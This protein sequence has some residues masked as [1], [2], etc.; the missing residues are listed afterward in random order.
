LPLDDKKGKRSDT[1]LFAERMKGYQRDW[2]E[3]KKTIQKL[4][5]FCRGNKVIFLSTKKHF[6]VNEKLGYWEEGVWYSNESHTY[7]MYTSPM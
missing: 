7:N 5:E 4:E 1:A 3:N 6:I 2:V